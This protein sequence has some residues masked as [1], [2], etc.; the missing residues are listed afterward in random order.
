MLPLLIKIFER[1]VH[2][3]VCNLIEKHNLFSKSQIGFRT[4]KSTSSAIMDLLEYIYK[5]LDSDDQVIFFFLDFRKA[6]NC[7]DH[8]IPLEKLQNFSVRGVTSRCSRSY[9]SNHYQYVSVNFVPSDF[10]LIM[11]VVPQGSIVEPL[12]FWIFINDFP[13]SK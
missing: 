13:N 6:L 12:L 5:N 3:Q 8:E 1:A 2:S 7:I 11:K 4:G 9:M 10:L